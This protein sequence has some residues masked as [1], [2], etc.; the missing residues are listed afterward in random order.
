MVCVR[1]EVTTTAASPHAPRQ[2]RRWTGTS[3]VSDSRYVPGW[4]RM[5]SPACAARSAAEMVVKCPRTAERLST[6]S[7]GSGSDAWKSADG[8]KNV[9]MCMMRSSGSGIGRLGARSSR[10]SHVSSAP[11]FL[12][13][14]ASARGS[15]GETDSGDSACDGVAASAG[16]PGGFD[17]R[18]GA[19]GCDCDDDG[20]GDDGNGD[21]DDDEGEDDDADGDAQDVATAVFAAA[22][23]MG[24]RGEPWSGS[25]TGACGRRR[26]RMRLPLTRPRL[27]AAAL[28]GSTL[29][30]ARALA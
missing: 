21:G 14:V 5:T 22:L 29:R 27:L 18:C 6:T 11:S 25:S 23:W 19:D 28:L 15:V 17:E 26:P 9:K 8:C 30:W 4:I 7:V 16:A 2:P 3:I 20:D 1:E 12:R 13:S 24:A 10:Q